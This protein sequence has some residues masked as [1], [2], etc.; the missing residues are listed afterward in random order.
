MSLTYG[1][2]VKE[3]K[4]HFVDLAED[5]VERAVAAMLPGATVINTF[6]ACKSRSKRSCKE[7]LTRLCFSEVSTSMVAWHEF[8]ERGHTQVAASAR[9]RRCSIR[10]YEGGNR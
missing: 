6:P 4:D 8:Q 7:V 3:Q 2:E 9:D 5:V 1:Y 10:I